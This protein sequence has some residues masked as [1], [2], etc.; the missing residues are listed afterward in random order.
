MLSFCEETATIVKK[1]NVF[2]V[3][4]NCGNSYVYM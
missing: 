4:A 1:T 2:L 3:W